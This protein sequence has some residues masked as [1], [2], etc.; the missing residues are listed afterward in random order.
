MGCQVLLPPVLDRE[1]VQRGPAPVAW[2]LPSEEAI[3]VVPE[4]EPVR[5]AEPLALVALAAWADR[6][7]RR[8]LAVTVSDRVKSRYAW[9]VGLLSALA[10]RTPFISDVTHADAWFP[11]CRASGAMGVDRLAENVGVLLNIPGEDARTAI[12]YMVREMIRNVEDHSRSGGP[13]FFAAGWFR[14]QGRVTFAV[15]DT[16]IGIRASLAA[17]GI[18]TGAE[19]DDEA[20][21]R[22]LQPHVTGAGEP[23]YAGAPGN[24]GVGLHMTRM[25]TRAC[26][27]QLL[28]Q[29]GSACFAEIKETET[30]TPCSPWKG[31]VVEVTIRTAQLPAFSSLFQAIV[32]RMTGSSN[33]KLQFTGGPREALELTPPVDGT[34]FAA[35]KGWY[36]AHRGNVHEELAD[37]GM[38]S[39]DFAKAKYTTQGAIHALL[40]EPLRTLGPGVL[41]NLWFSN[42]GTQIRAVLT[43]VVAYA[44]DHHR[45]G[46]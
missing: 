5:H 3:E 8:G 32:T 9:N 45:A 13:A 10:G 27:G 31:T 37:G 33:W 11:I 14:N 18:V 42:A 38:V 16:G 46:Q 19:G 26:N 6:L 22:A 40:Y 44:L 15:A 35:D 12:V 36:A 30:F 25:I 17:R 21:E 7:K 23:E 24:A 20:I 28:V 29:S 41:P 1:F 43:Q 39:I 4:G 2:E 34:G